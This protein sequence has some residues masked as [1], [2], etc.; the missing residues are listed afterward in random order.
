VDFSLFPTLILGFSAQQSL[1]GSGRP[2]SP[3]LLGPFLDGGCFSVLLFFDVD[4]FNS[5]F[6]GENFVCSAPLFFMFSVI[7]G[8]FLL[9][10][11]L[12]PGFCQDSRSFD[13]D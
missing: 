11:S 5:F 4:G 8:G 6:E 9:N 2:P 12:G 13:F 1:P 3:A 10:D 7:L